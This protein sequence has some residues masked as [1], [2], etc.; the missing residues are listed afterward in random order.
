[1]HGL[2][3]DFA[4]DYPTSL[5]SQA[6]AIFTYLS[7]AAFSILTGIAPSGRSIRFTPTSTNLL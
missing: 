4:F 6:S 3:L 1:M 2:M 5:A 7:P